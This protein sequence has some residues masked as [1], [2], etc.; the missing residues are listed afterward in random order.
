MDKSN[1]NVFQPNLGNGPTKMASQKTVVEPTEA[2]PNVKHVVGT[3][4]PGSF[5]QKGGPDI[6]PNPNQKTQSGSL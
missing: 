2:A 5:S 1:G 3:L 6:S 4:M